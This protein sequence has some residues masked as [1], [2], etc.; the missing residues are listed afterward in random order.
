MLHEGYGWTTATGKPRRFGVGAGTCRVALACLRE[1]WS[2]DRLHEGLRAI[3]W[4][5]AHAEGK[6]ATGKFATLAGMLGG[7]QK[8]EPG[9]S[10]KLE[11]ALA[12][13]EDAGCPEAAPVRAPVPARRKGPVRIVEENETPW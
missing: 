9:K 13:F 10:D 8:L 11:R 3:C 2:L 5:E 12:D 1:G 4:R 7:G 6:R